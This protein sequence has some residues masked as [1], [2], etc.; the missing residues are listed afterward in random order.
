MSQTGLLQG[1]F[2]VSPSGTAGPGSWPKDTVAICQ[3]EGSVFP[4]SVSALQTVVYSHWSSQVSGPPGLFPVLVFS[5][6]NFRLH[7]PGNLNLSILTLSLKY[8]LLPYQKPN[9]SL[10]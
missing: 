2:C 1:G 10:T 5:E 6:E 9:S 8:F 3:T 4:F 7:V